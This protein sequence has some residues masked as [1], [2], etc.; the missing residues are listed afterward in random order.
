[1]DYS[2]AHELVNKTILPAINTG[3]RR[4]LPDTFVKCTTRDEE[5]YRNANGCMYRWYMAAISGVSKLN[6]SPKYSQTKEEMIEGDWSSVQ[7]FY[8]DMLVASDFLKFLI[9]N[10]EIQ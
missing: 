7:R 6:F 2:E 8:D 3:F 4:V 9:E 1:M 10:V 5:V